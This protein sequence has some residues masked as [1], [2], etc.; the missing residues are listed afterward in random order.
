MQF[1]NLRREAQLG[2]TNF[3]ANLNVDYRLP[4]PK[5]RCFLCRLWV[6][7]VVD[8]RKGYLRAQIED[9]DRKRVYVESTSLYVVPR[10][11]VTSE[12]CDPEMKN[13]M[14]PARQ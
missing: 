12:V 7:K 10:S 13:F 2:T 1:G 8:G 3:T 11:H 14:A 4:M 6:E 9:R 5:N